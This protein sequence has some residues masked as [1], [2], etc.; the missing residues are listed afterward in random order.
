MT[1]SLQRWNERATDESGGARD[2]HSHQFM[3]PCSDPIA[4]T[5][6]AD[7]PFRSEA[8]SADREA[9]C[10]W[11]HVADRPELEATIASSSRLVVVCAHASL[12]GREP[13]RGEVENQRRR[14]RRMRLVRRRR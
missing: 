6:R 9:W 7:W 3:L 8:A 1:V 12:R 2:K 4:R 11:V 5:R 13:R 14:T 10:A